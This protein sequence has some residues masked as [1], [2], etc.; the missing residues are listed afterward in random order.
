MRFIDRRRELAA[1]GKFWKEKES[2][3]IVI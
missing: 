3:L 1:L 2:Q